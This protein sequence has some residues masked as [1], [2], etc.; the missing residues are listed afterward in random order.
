MGDSFNMTEKEHNRNLGIDLLRIVSMFM[1][2]L[3]HV[4][5]QGGILSPLSIH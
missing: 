1:I 4:L 2:V 3:L 5:G